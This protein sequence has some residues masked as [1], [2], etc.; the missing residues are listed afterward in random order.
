MLRFDMETPL[1]ALPHKLRY[2]ER[3]FNFLDGCAD[4]EC[5]D[6]RHIDFETVRSFSFQV[7]HIAILMLQAFA[8]S[9]SIGQ[10]NKFES[11]GINDDITQ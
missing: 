2:V 7:P 5:R 10:L 6:P 1:K 9:L 11:F 3:P 8:Y 4:N